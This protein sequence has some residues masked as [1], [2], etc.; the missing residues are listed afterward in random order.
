M[1]FLIVILCVAYM[2]Y[3]NWLWWTLSELKMYDKK[4][5][6]SEVKLKICTL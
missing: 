1:F 5:K 4:L 6:M 2:F 3:L